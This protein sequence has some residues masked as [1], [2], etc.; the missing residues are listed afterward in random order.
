MGGS[1]AIIHDPETKHTVDQDTGEYLAMAPTHW[2]APY[3]HCTIYHADGAPLSGAD[4]ERIAVDET[5]NSGVRN[6]GALRCAESLGAVRTTSKPNPS[7]RGRHYNR[8][9]ACVSR[10][11]P[12][13]ARVY[14]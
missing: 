3:L 6:A 14:S 11:P 1:M 13:R 4:V 9:A 2:Q 5:G 10:T 7:Q 12:A 8:E